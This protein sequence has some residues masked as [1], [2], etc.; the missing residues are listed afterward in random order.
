[1]SAHLQMIGLLLIGGVFVFAGIDHFVRFKQTIALLA[2]QGLPLPG[3][4]LAAGSAVEVVA[5]LCLAAGFYQPYAALV[6]VVFTI[7]A[8]FMLLNFWRYSGEQRQ[9]LRSA[10]IINVAV[11]GGLLV[12]AAGG[13]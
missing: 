2:E 1:M 7:A 10:F 6:L 5:G 12:A 3:L 8:S 9:G 4:T 13:A 11:I